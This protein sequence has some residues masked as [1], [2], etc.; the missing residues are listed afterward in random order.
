MSVEI[1]LAKKIINTLFVNNNKREQNLETPI[2]LSLER[3][4]SMVGNKFPKKPLSRKEE[5]QM[6]PVNLK[7]LE[8]VSHKPS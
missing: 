3:D 7:L 8:G 2:R 5:D 4:E 6:P 1:F